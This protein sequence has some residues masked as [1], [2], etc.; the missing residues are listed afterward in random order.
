MKT[1]RTDSGDRREYPDPG[2][3]PQNLFFLQEIEGVG[4]IEFG[5]IG[6]PASRGGDLRDAADG[7]GSAR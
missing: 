2:L 3:Q 5:G 1:N 4:W 6:D 7:T